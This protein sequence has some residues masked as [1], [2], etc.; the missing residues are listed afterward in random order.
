M[1]ELK[2]GLVHLK[3][4][5]MNTAM[6]ILSAAAGYTAGILTHTLLVARRIRKKA[7]SNELQ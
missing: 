6:L 5:T 1:I 3:L 4:S 7:R 2:I